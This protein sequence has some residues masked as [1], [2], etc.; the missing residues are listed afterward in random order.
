MSSTESLEPANIFRILGKTEICIDE[1]S[2]LLGRNSKEVCKIILKLRA[3]GIA[4]FVCSER[5]KR[6]PVYLR[7][8]GLC[9]F[10]RIEKSFR[11]SHIGFAERFIHIFA[12]K[13]RLVRCEFSGV[14]L[15]ISRCI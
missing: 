9:S 2:V 3:S 13:E 12:D 4:E 6:L 8:F 10:K 1:F 7:K 11:R 15:I 5:N 14:F